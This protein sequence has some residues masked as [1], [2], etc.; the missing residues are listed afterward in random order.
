MKIKIA[1][2]W[3]PNANHAG[4]YLALFNGWYKE[5]DLDIEL[6]LPKS[7]ENEIA[8]I[9]KLFRK[10]VSLA[11][12][13][14]EMVIRSHQNGYKELLA[15]AATL[16]GTPTAFGALKSS[17][18]NSIEKLKGKTYAALEIP[19]EKPLISQLTGGNYNSITPQILDIYKLLFDGAADFAWVFKNIEVVEARLKGLDL[20]VFNH[21]EAGIPYGPCSLIVA[22]RQFTDDYSFLA[23]KFLEVT[24]R[25]Y[26]KVVEDPMGA[27]EILYSKGAKFFPD[28]ELLVETIKASCEY[29]L[30]KEGTWG[31]MSEERWDAYLNWLE[32]KEQIR[33]SNFN[34]SLLYSNQFLTVD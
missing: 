10:E 23:Q 29:Y 4:L 21:E 26:K 16:Q 19:F 3:I 20:N 27:A 7:D 2:D 25:A 15:I 9:E 11:I 32:K 8:P 30:T 22:H 14:C 33:K 18:I 17:G 5:A 13:P 6:V 28:K 31:T 34:L 24:S 1:L 12:A